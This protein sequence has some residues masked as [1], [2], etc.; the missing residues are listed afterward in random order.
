LRSQI[1]GLMDKLKA[2]ESSRDPEEAKEVAL[3]THRTLSERVQ[4]ENLFLKSKVTSLESQLA[5]IQKRPEPQLIIHSAKYGPI[6][7]FEDVTACVQAMVRNNRLEVSIMDGTFQMY[8]ADPD[9]LAARRLMSLG[10]WL[11]K[12]EYS[13]GAY[14]HKEV[15]RSQFENL[16]LPEEADRN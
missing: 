2:L 5:D 10:V 1:V 13:Y 6:D 8:F 4:K 16:Q 15:A 11:L 7:G 9:K 14:K 3:R 12:V